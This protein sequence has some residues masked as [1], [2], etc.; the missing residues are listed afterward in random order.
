MEKLTFVTKSIKVNNEDITGF[1]KELKIEQEPIPK[2]I[3]FYTKNGRA[4]IFDNRNRDFYYSDEEMIDLIV[5]TFAIDRSKIYEIGFD[6][7]I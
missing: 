3:H 7:V 2:E 4:Y 6:Y 5:T 1:F